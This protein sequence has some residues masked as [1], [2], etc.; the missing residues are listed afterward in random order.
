MVAVQKLRLPDLM[1]IIGIKT[2]LYFLM[3]F[4]K[5]NKG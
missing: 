1:E 2:L 5:T 3:Y 4:K